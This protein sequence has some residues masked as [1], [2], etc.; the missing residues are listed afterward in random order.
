MAVSENIFVKFDGEAERLAYE[1]SVR[2]LAWDPVEHELRGSVER[3]GADPLHVVLHDESCHCGWYSNDW[4]ERR[5]QRLWR[6]HVAP[7]RLQ[8]DR[9]WRYLEIGV[10]E[11]R[12]MVWA[13]QH[14]APLRSVGIDPWRPP[15]L[16]QRAMM[17]EYKRRAS[18]NLRPWTEDGSCRLVLGDSQEWLRGPDSPEDGWADL[19][20]VDGDHRGHRAQMDLVLALAK[21]RVGGLLVFD[22]WDRRWVRSQPNAWEAWTGFELAHSHLLEWVYRDK[23]Q[24][25]VRKKSDGR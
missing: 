2:W 25:C 8:Q 19:A 23:Q 1:Q 7:L 16:R 15:K 10:C 3:E 24:V 6:E 17:L 9:E 12:S 5:T 20:F 21:L 18:R 14:L 22:D 11:G 13:M 4:F